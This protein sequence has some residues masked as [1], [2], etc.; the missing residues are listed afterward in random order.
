MSSLQGHAGRSG[1]PHAPASLPPGNLASP[2]AA[3]QGPQLPRHR[4]QIAGRVAIKRERLCPCAL[5]SGAAGE[6]GTT[7]FLFSSFRPAPASHASS[8]P[9]FCLSIHLF[10]NQ[11]P[12]RPS[13]HAS[14]CLILRIHLLI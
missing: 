9:S 4:S 12:Y 14:I 10:A 2:R 1:G 7:P 13:V 5:L 8:R 3:G 11:P 6:A